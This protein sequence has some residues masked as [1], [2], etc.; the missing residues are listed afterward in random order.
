M[1]IAD[2]K[3]YARTDDE[4]PVAL[5][6]T[7]LKEL[8]ASARGD[9]GSDDYLRKMAEYQAE[10]NRRALRPENEQH[11][12]ISVYSNPDGD[13]K[14]QKPDLKAKVFWV[15]YPLEK[16]T[17]TPE[18]VALINDLQPGNYSFTRTDGTKAQ[19]EVTARLDAGG[20]IAR[21]EVVFPAKGDA[22]KTL[23]PMTVMLREMLGKPSREAELAALVKAL[24]AQL[25][26]A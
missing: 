22:H 21:L 2:P 24:E 12:G 3:T 23:P 11:P 17:L 16:D 9:Q 6:M 14:D 4:R 13:L 10:A 19:A 7:Q 15:G 1:A 26:V 20:A 25:A 5:T 8:I 18:E